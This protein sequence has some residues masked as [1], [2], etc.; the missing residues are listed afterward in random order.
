MAKKGQTPWNKG[1]K[2]STEHKKNLSI[3]HI[4]QKA[5]NKG[6]K[7][8]QKQSLESRKRMSKYAKEH[9][10]GKWTKGK[11]AWNKDHTQ[12]TDPRVRKYTQTRINSPNYNETKKK[13]GR[14]NAIALKGNIPHNKGKNKN[15]YS[16][17]LKTSLKL[18]EMGDKGLLPVQTE[19]GKTKI[20]TARAKQKNNKVSETEMF[21]RKKFDELEIKYIPQQDFLLKNGLF[22]TLVDLYFPQAKL[23]VYA[24]GDYWHANPILYKADYVLKGGE[25]AQQIWDE[26]RKITQIL[27]ENNYLV[28]RFWD[29]EIEKDSQSCINKILDL[30][31]LSVK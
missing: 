13:I 24:D 15:N 26:D 29:S 7:G 19:I 30:L 3:S 11:D 6:R 12:E 9:G 1:K 8:V 25:T 31:K 18:K 28:L 17:T 27:K 4:G 21:L 20:R 23:C 14:A 10:F 2:L 22:L 16:P 5:W